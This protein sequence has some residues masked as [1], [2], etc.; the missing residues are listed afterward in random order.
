MSCLLGRSRLLWRPVHNRGAFAGFRDIIPPRQRLAFV[1][2]KYYPTARCVLSSTSY[3]LV[4][5]TPSSPVRRS[6]P[7]SP[8]SHNTLQLLQPPSVAEDMAARPDH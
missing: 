4:L 8:S 6:V 2:R 3:V 1:T 7:I 5:C